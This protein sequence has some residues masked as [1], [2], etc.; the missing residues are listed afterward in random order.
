MVLPSFLFSPPIH[1][2]LSP[3]KAFFALLKLHYNISLMKEFVKSSY[4]LKNYQDTI[5]ILHGWGSSKE[6]WQAVKE[7]LEKQGL[8]VI[9]PDLPGFKKETKLKN[10]WDL[11]DYV[12]WFKNKYET[13]PHL[14]EIEPRKDHRFFLL[15]HSFGG[16]IGIKYAAQHPEKLKGLI[17]VSAAGIK[18]KRNLQSRLISAVA[19]FGQRF[20]SLPFYFS[21]RKVFYRFILR[22]TDY[23]KSEEIPNL[24]ETFKKIIA[25][26]L[27]DYLEKIKTPCLIIWGDKDK[28]TLLADAYLMNKKIPNSKLEILKNIGHSPHRETPIDLANKVVNFIKQNF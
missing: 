5:I 15:G 20:S 12:D 11:D 26:D 13:Q 21:A 16:R 3:N 1:F 24:K 17:L 23:I 9:I 4:N 19:R 27:T 14:K 28:E 18:P 22:R 7:N 10:P 2:F 6:K 8:K 25:E